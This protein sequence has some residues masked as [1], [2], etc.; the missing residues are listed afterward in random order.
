MEDRLKEAE[1]IVRDMEKD[2]DLSKIE[3]LI[4]DNK[5]TFTHKEKK[6]RVRLLN[7][8]EKDELDLLRRKK[9]GQL[10]KDKDILFEKDI[11]SQYKE[12]GLN[13]FEEADIELKKLDS[14]ML[15]LEL[16]LGESISK[17]EAESVLK[18]YKNQIQDILT[19]KKVLITQRNLLLEFSFENALLNY[20]YQVICYLSLDIMKD[21]R[22]NRMF[23][24][25][26]EFQKHD[27][28]SLINK[29]ASYSILLQ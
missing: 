4:R 23:S 20:V 13:V 26:E 6:Y 10:L 17:N 1:R 11:L 27:D 2:S 14:A 3:E 12:R 9:F 16:K 18:N 29:A 21:G 5:I 25:L 22:W 8:Y 7:T 19:K 28:E 24:S 15:D